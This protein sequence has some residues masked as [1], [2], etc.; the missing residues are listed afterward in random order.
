MAGRT[1][2][3]SDAWENRHVRDTACRTTPTGSK[4]RFTRVQAD[5]ENLLMLWFKF[6]RVLSLDDAELSGSRHMLVRRDRV[7]FSLQSIPVT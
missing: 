3:D 5:P 7:R 4:S 2:A 1:V 6:H